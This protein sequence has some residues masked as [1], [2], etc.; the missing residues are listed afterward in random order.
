MW[1]W[2]RVV[3]AEAAGE[4]MV[5]VVVAAF[6]ALPPR[7]SYDIERRD[8]LRGVASMPSDAPSDARALRPPA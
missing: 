5:V 6:N 7:N 2:P 4:V 8:A 3:A 1:W